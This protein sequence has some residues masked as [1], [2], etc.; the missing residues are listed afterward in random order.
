MPS[1]DTAP[2]HRWNPQPAW[3]SYAFHLPEPGCVYFIRRFNNGDPIRAYYSYSRKWFYVDHEEVNFIKVTH[4][5]ELPPMNGLE[6]LA[7]P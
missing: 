6:W 7:V 2:Y 3:L 1:Y 4:G 5:E